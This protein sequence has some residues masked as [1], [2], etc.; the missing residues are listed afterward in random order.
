MPKQ[1]PT[2]KLTALEALKK[3]LAEAEKMRDEY[4]SGWQR[5]KADFENYKKHE[6]DKTAKDREYFNRDWVLRILG[7][8]DNLEMAESHLPQGLKDNEWV[9][10]VLEIQRQFLSSIEGL[11]EIKAE[12]EK[13]DPQVHEAVEQVEAEDES[14]TV[15]EVLQKGYKLNGAVIRPAKVKVSK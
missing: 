6:A 14:D 4:L 7:L 3:Q 11:E 15:V 2:K 13:F 5:C 12:G 8:Y 1:K 10:A 9:K